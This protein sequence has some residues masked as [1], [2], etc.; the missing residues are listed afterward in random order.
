MDMAG[1]AVSVRLLRARPEATFPAK[2]SCRVRITIQDFAL[3]ALESLSFV[4]VSYLEEGFVRS[5]GVERGDLQPLA[6][7]CTKV[8]NIL[9]FLCHSIF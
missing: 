4:Q 3:T 9:I 8:S 7:Q 5:L 2:V 1:F 6:H